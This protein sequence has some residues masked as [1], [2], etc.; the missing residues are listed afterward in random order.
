MNHY[1]IDLEIKVPKHMDRESFEEV[2]DEMAD[3]AA[4]ITDGVDCDVS[5]SIRDR[6]ITLHLTL[7]GEDDESVFAHGMAAARTVLHTIG[8][9]TPGWEQVRLQR[10][11]K[12]T[13]AT[14]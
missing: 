7:D 10:S 14:C 12:D 3:V 13:L 5:A 9:D 1:L 11:P 2:F 8:W 4:D 6:M